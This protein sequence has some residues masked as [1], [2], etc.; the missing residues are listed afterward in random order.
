MGLQEEA[1]WEAVLSKDGSMNG[2]F[3]TGVHST[4]IYCL[5]S[6]PARKPKRVNV[7]FYRDPADAQTDGLRACKK[8]RPDD[9]Y[10]GVD[11]ARDR[12]VAT[13]SQVFEC[14]F[15]FPDVASV[16]DAFGQSAGTLHHA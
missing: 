14:P 16:V 11:A 6:C 5:P 12:L 13:I 9:F 15:R 7:R 8:C 10:S 4:G 2:R 1:M 3:I